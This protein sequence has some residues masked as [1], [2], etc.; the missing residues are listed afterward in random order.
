MHR[1]APE[2]A[3]RGTGRVE[4]SNHNQLLAY[5]CEHGLLANNAECEMLRA[6]EQF[7]YLGSLVTE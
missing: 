2:L 1:L 7:Q 4:K 6:Y 5:C 3:K